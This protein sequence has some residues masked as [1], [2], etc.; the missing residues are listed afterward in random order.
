MFCGRLLRIGL[1]EALARGDWAKAAVPGTQVRMAN[2]LPRM[3]ARRGVCF[4]Q[5]SWSHRSS[6]LKHT[7]GGTVVL[8]YRTGCRGSS[9]RRNQ[10]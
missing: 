10:Q 3:R 9:C 8:T 7:P 5:W 4:A 2:T 6:T 1:L